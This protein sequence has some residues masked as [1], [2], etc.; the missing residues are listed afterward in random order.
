MTWALTVSMPHWKNWWSIGKA[1]QRDNIPF[2]SQRI[3]GNRTN[4]FGGKLWNS[5]CEKKTR[6]LI[7]FIAGAATDLYLRVKTGDEGNL[8]V[9][10][11]VF[12]GSFFIVYFL[13]YILWRLK[14]KHTNWSDKADIELLAAHTHFTTV[15]SHPCNNTAK[16]QNTPVGTVGEHKTAAF[17]WCEGK[18]RRPSL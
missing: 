8:L 16:L 5:S 17:P 2:V 15:R 12:L 4:Y 3:M 9:H 13:L 10:S 1:K 6:L 18:L 7:S 11:V 14:E